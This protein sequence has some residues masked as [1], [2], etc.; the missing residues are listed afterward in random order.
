M[1]TAFCLQPF[2]SPAPGATASPRRNSGC[3]MDDL[4]EKL[5]QSSAAAQKAAEALWAI[6]EPSQ[7][8]EPGAASASSQRDAEPAPPK[9]GARKRPQLASSSSSSSPS[10]PPKRERH[11]PLAEA[12]RHEIAKDQGAAGPGEVPEQKHLPEQEEKEEGGEAPDEVA[13][14]AA[15]EDAGAD[16]A[17]EDAGASEAAPE[18][19]AK[20]DEAAPD[21]AAKA[22][23]AAEEAAE[24]AWSGEGDVEGDEAVQ[25]AAERAWWAEQAAEADAAAEHAEDGPFWDE[26]DQWA[27][28]A[29]QDAVVRWF[30]REEAEARRAFADPYPTAEDAAAGHRSHYSDEAR[31]TMRAERDMASAAG[32]TRWEAMRGPLGPEEG[33]PQ[34]WRGQVFRPGSQRWA[35]RGGANRDFFAWKYGGGRGKGRGGKDGGGKKGGGRG[36]GGKDGGGKSTSA[37]SG[38]RWRHL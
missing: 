37:S 8:T 38:S 18:Q 36:R 22:D 15:E 34:T 12:A 2:E 13:D 31:R 4:D 35:N 20:A 6:G 16:E 29:H 14:G 7:A 19:E 32:M 23:Q 1:S 21:Q 30:W 9:P 28:D 5:A 10:P 17:P 33:G 27:T 11:P 25:E 3:A 24:R 26:E